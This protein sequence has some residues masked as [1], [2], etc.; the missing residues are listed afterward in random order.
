M[1]ATFVLLLVGLLGGCGAGEAELDC[2]VPCSPCDCIYADGSNE[3]FDGLLW[4]ENNEP[5][6]CVC[7]PTAIVSCEAAEGM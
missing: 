4:C 3:H 1:R 5:T 2:T 6:D 7:D